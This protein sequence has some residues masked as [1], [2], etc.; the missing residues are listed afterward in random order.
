MIELC[1]ICGFAF[2][3]REGDKICKDCGKTEKITMTDKKS[4]LKVRL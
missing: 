2:G 3:W 1:E 4:I